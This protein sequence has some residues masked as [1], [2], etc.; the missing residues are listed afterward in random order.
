MKRLE[1]IVDVKNK[2]DLLTGCQSILVLI[3]STLE[4]VQKN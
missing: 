2:D 3:E 1:S 4:K